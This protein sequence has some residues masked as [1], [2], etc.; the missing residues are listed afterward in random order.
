MA[1][2]PY[3]PAPEPGWYD[4]DPGLNPT[5]EPAEVPVTHG[6]SG[7]SLDAGLAKKGMVQSAQSVQPA[8]RVG[9]AD[10]KDDVEDWD[11]TLLSDSFTLKSPTLVYRLHNEAT[12][13]DIVIDKSVLL[14][15]KPSAIV[16]A[17]AK[18]ERVEDPT[19]TVSRN[20]ASISFAQDGQLWIEDYGSLNGSY[21]I[22]GDE[23]TTVTQGKPV[24]LEA[25]AIVRL[26]DQFFD[27]TQD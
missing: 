16:P 27:F 10:M 12:G 9:I 7:Q 24:A 4:D 23:E 21:I 2:L 13:Q 14:G 17:G 20:H 8:I 5:V 3:P 25:P 15:R 18:S 22:R 26:G 1:H 11:G 6:L 19:R